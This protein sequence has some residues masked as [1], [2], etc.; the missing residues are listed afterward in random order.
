ML[1]LEISFRDDGDV[2]G[3]TGQIRFQLLKRVGLRQ[4]GGVEDVDGGREDAKGGGSKLDRWKSN[5]A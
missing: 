1:F 4:R 5:A 3:I 2:D